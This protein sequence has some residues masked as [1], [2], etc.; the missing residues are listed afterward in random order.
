MSAPLLGV[1]LEKSFACSLFVGATYIRVDR[2]AFRHPYSIRDLSDVEKVFPCS[3]ILCDNER[4][5]GFTVISDCGQRDTRWRLI[6]PVT[7]DEEH[8]GILEDLTK[9]LFIIAVRIGRHG[10]RIMEHS[11]R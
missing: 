11:P 9:D 1:P 4:K 6:R 3:T 2:R 7:R 5:G 8:R 10:P